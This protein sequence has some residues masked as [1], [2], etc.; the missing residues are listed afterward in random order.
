MEE[1]WD[2]AFQKENEGEVRASRFSST[3]GR[4]L[5]LANG[6]WIVTGSF[7]SLGLGR[8]RCELVFY[9]SR[10][11]MEEMRASVPNDVLH[12]DW[13][14]KRGQ[15]LAVTTCGS[16]DT[17]WIK[18][19]DH[20]AQAL[21]LIDPRTRKIEATPLWRDSGNSDFDW[22][23]SCSPFWNGNE[24]GVPSDESN[25]STLPSNQF[26]FRTTEFAKV[27]VTFFKRAASESQKHLSCLRP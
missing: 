26:R 21:V 5:L 25:P 22:D 4:R 15:F 19:P 17:R 8:G 12:M 24:I 6:E 20:C 1:E 27:R 10:T 23:G 16:E 14:E 9:D 3:E 11:L 7:V 18:Y 13:N 2:Y